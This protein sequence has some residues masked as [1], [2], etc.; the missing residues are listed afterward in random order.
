MIFFEV[1][2]GNGGIRF[3]VD[4]SKAH[5]TIAVLISRPFSHTL[6]L[7]FYSVSRCTQLALSQPKAG[8]L[9]K[10]LFFIPTSFHLEI[11][12]CH[13]SAIELELVHEA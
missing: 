10:H 12:H 2:I 3:I 11:S 5:E 9:I 4:V 1:K 6:A 13:R 7:N 8:S